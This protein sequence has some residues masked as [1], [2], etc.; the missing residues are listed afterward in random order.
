MA[1]MQSYRGYEIVVEA[2]GEGWRVF[3]HPRTPDLPI[4]RHRS[5]HVDADT[6]NDA[7]EEARKR[8]DDLLRP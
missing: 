6:T 2:N 8:I 3:A 7:L 1:E 4:T 5:F